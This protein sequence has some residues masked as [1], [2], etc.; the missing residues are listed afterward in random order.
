MLIDLVI[1]SLTWKLSK[2]NYWVTIRS[3]SDQPVIIYANLPLDTKQEL[4]IQAQDS[5]KDYLEKQSLKPGILI[6]RGH[7]YHLSNTL[8]RLQP[9]VKLAVLG[10]C[11]GYNSVISVA[12]INPDTQIIVTKKQDQNASM[13]L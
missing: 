13:I 7:S 4:D 2:N 6:H 1:L 5:L 3:L 10:S 12:N 8:K 9:S 11:G